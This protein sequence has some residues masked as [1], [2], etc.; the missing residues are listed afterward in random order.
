MTEQPNHE[1]L[2]NSLADGWIEAHPDSTVERAEVVRQLRA[3]ANGD[4]G[5][6]VKAREFLGM[7][8]GLAA[9]HAIGAAQTEHDDQKEN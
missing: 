5:T 4:S 8:D 2:I 7:A 6:E 1:D 3:V 9:A